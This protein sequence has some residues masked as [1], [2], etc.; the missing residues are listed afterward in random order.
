MRVRLNAIAHAD[1]DASRILMQTRTP[2]KYL[3]SIDGQQKALSRTFAAVAL[4]SAA[5]VAPQAQAGEAAVRNTL[6]PIAIER[7][8]PTPK[9]AADPQARFAEGV[10]LAK[11]GKSAQ[12]IA[13][14]TELTRDHP[15]LAEPHNNLGVL[16]EESGDLDRARAAL[17]LAVKADSEYSTA[18]EN[19]GDLYA[20]IASLFYEKALRINAGSPAASSG[21]TILSSVGAFPK[22]GRAVKFAEIAAAPAEAGALEK[23]GSDYARRA[24]QAYI[25]ARQ[26]DPAGKGLS[27][28][29]SLLEKM[30]VDRPAESA[31][32]PA[33]Q[34]TMA[35]SVDSQPAPAQR[36]AL[37]AQAE[38]AGAQRVAPEAPAPKAA[39]AA[40]N[41]LNNPN[42]PNDPL[43]LVNQWAGAWS[44]RDVTRYLSF[45]APYFKTPNG[46]TVDAWK[47]SRAARISGKS[48]ISVTVEAPRVTLDGDIAIV[49]FRQVYASD[50]F[51]ET[52]AKILVLT[53]HDDSWQILEERTGS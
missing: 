17:E 32:P 11:E 47:K 2:M 9:G 43:A 37:P 35:F 24:Y 45:Y 38:N 14:F 52:S 40:R 1:S 12:A 50:S 34:G 13:I 33:E 23:L 28:K 51:R 16:Y 41:N 4:W 5:A 29:T 42:H 31:S 25:R 19:L 49:K 48:R 8:A 53:R 10:K 44:A 18:S 15:D 20:Q 27:M 6:V 30:M 36:A 26:I 22:R 7:S 3:P 21:S 39:G 46:Q